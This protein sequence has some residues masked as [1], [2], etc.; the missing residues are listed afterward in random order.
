MIIGIRQ[1]KVEDLFDNHDCP[2]NTLYSTTVT[3]DG[4]HFYA[5]FSH[6]T[7]DICVYRGGRLVTVIPN[8]TTDTDIV[9]KLIND[10]F[11]NNPTLRYLVSRTR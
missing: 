7:P 1:W 6:F 3:V 5:E 2:V 11:R 8:K 9:D 10:A 4:V